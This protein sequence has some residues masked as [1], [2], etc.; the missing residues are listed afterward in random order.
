MLGGKVK[1]GLYG[2]RPALA[3]LDGTG[4]LPH[5]V[6]LRELYA[7]VLDRW[8]GVGSSGPLRGRYTPL[9]VLRA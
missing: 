5:A 7:T 8:W 2:E 9:E 6:D 4:N 1:G 3:R